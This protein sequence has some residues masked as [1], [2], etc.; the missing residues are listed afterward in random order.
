MACLSMII[1]AHTQKL[2]DQEH[3]GHFFDV[4]IHPKFQDCF[5]KNFSHTLEINGNE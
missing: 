3:M 4:H 2:F 1:Y 5:E